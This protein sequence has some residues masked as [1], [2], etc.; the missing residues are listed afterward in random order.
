MGGWWQVTEKDLEELAETARKFLALALWH[1][2]REGEP[3]FPQRE[4]KAK[5]AASYLRAAG[6]VSRAI[7]LA[8]VRVEELRLEQ[9]KRARLE[10]ESRRRLEE[11]QRTPPRVGEPGA[12]G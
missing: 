6:E 2:G 1:A 10:E 4:R 8:R 12:A 5:E 9:E 3:P 11:W 7:A